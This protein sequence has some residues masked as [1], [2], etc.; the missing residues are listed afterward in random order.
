MENRQQ[1]ILLPQD[2]T[3]MLMVRFAVTVGTTQILRQIL[4]YGL[5][6]RAKIMA[7]CVCVM[8]AHF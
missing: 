5:E 2:R 8:T 3:E 4:R 1:M 7:V 6:N